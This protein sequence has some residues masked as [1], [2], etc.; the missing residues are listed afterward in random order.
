MSESSATAVYLIIA[1]LHWTIA[2]WKCTAFLRSPNLSLG[3]Q[4]A[5][6]SLGGTVYLVA[7]PLG[8]RTLGA[9]TGHPWLPTL[10]IYLGILLC[11]GNQHL[12]TMVWTAAQADPQRR[13]RRRLWAWTIA[14]VVS[15]AIMIVEF[16]KADLDGPADP[17]KFNTEQVDELHVRVFLAVF[18]VM[19]ACGTLNAGLHS[20]R[21]RIDDERLRHSIRWYGISHLVTFGY[22]LCSAPAAAAAA[23]GHHQLDGVG[24]LGAAFGCVGSVLTCYGVSGAVVSTWL[25]ERRDIAVLQPLWDLVVPG[26]AEELALGARGRQAGAFTQPTP[27]TPG[28][29]RPNRLFNVRWT[30]HRRVI[31][32]LDGIR[33]LERSSMV[34]KLPAHVVTSLHAEAV[35]APTLRCQLGLGKKAL[36]LVDVEAAATAA[37]LR[38]AVERLQAAGPDGPEPVSPPGTQPIFVPGKGTPAAKERQRLVRVARALHH[39]L[40]EASLRAVRSVH[41]DQGAPQASATAR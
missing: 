10:P 22:V 20:W 36:T 37:V 7:S 3:L 19:L 2:C 21:A 12:L 6:H 5:T 34:R 28:P 1:S 29:S 15:M 14:Y 24:V 16:V 13:L 30:L 18:L 35:K 25:R 11:F 33:R 39:P 41:G 4:T 31:E 26:V 23:T 27:R 38:D 40:T 32:I 17:L 9:A 8:Y